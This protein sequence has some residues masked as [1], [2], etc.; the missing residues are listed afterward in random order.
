MKISLKK[1]VCAMAAAVVAFSVTSFLPG[2]SASAD[3]P[4]LS[5][6][7]EIRYGGF[8][9]DSENATMSEVTG[10]QIYFTSRD[11]DYFTTDNYVPLYTPN[12]TLANSCGATAAPSS[13]AST[14][15]ITKTLSP[16]IRHTTRQ[17]AGTSR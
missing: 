15:S 16:A 1:C 4:S 11:D 9:G 2:M 12:T 7:D 13:S 3:E 10:E 8:Y 6:S 5:A 14:I 17:T